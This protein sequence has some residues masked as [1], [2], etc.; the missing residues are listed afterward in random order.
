MIN[1]IKTYLSNKVILFI[2][3]PLSGKSTQAKILSE[4]LD[5]S[6][7]ST[8]DIFR[9]I[10]ESISEPEPESETDI[11]NK[12]KHYMDQRKLISDD[13]VS[14]ILI[15][16]IS[17]IDYT[18]GLILETFPC[19]MSNIAIFDK[20]LSY[21]DL[22]IL[23]I[24][25]INV[26]YL[27][28][29]DRFNIISETSNKSDDKLEIFNYRQTEYLKKTLDVINYY[30]GLNKV[31]TIDS[32]HGVEIV[33]DNIINSIFDY[34]KYNYDLIEADQLVNKFIELNKPRKTFKAFALP[35]LGSIIYKK[36]ILTSGYSDYEND[37]AVNS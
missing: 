24:I 3:P 8:E 15:K 29:L 12:I 26:D 10:S 7:V 32:N 18:N 27:S 2:G 4:L 34:I 13:R 21:L 19:E 5:I 35:I 31:I 6:Y 20:I 33:R 16:K 30:V 36:L 23:C 9:K 28:L 1:I 11:N 25:H 37:D 17:E 14:Q 22:E